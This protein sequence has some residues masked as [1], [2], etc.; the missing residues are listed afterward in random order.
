MVGVLNVTYRREGVARR[1]ECATILRRRKGKFMT[2][3]QLLS[4]N[5]TLSVSW[6]HV[7]YDFECAHDEIMKQLSV[8]L[9]APREDRDMNSKQHV[10]VVF[11]ARCAHDSLPSCVDPARNKAVEVEE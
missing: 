2:H 3:S 6:L 11:L 4:R 9:V 1:H 7:A 8:V 5:L 10:F